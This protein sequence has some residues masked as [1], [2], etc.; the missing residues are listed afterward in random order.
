MKKTLIVATHNTH[1]TEEICEMLGDFFD[2]ITDLT[3]FPHLKPAEETAT[4][5]SG[6]S[7]IKALAA[8]TEMPEA[9]VLADDSGLEVDALNGEPGVYSSRY[10]GEGATDATNREKLVAELTKSGAKGKDR[11]ARFRCVL[12]IARGGSVIEEFDGAVEGIIANEEKGESGF[13]YDSLF[14]PEGYCETFGQLS[15][16]IKNGMSHRARALG[17]LKLWLQDSGGAPE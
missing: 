6:N 13:G 15:A 1:K 5:F 10:S 7:A 11:S 9:L 16:E 12:S 4:T 14:I 8:S 2:E 3:A 17:K